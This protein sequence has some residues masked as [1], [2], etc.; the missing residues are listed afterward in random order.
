M[1]AKTTNSPAYVVYDR[2]FQSTI[3]ATATGSGGTITTTNPTYHR[4]GDLSTATQWQ[5]SNANIVV[6]GISVVFDYEKILSNCLL[7][8]KVQYTAGSTHAGQVY[9]E[10]SVDGTN[11]TALENASTLDATYTNSTNLTAYAGECRYIRLRFYHA[12]DTS[13]NTIKAY[14][15]RLMGSG[16]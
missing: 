13:T 11:Y 3:T 5:N 15:L 6:G 8:Y 1:G 16:N 7:S 2:S 10:Y 4:D 12:D 14:E 9:L